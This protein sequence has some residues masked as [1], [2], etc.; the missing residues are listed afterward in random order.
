LLDFLRFF[1]F[2]RWCILF[3]EVY[4]RIS[5]R[6]IVFYYNF[7]IYLSNIRF[8]KILW[9]YFIFQRLFDI[10]L[11]IAVSLDSFSQ[12]RILIYYFISKRKYP[13]QITLFI[14]LIIFFFLFLNFFKL[15]I[16]NNSRKLFLI[17]ILFI[18]FFILK[19]IQRFFWKSWCWDLST[20][21]D[22]LWYFYLKC[23]IDFSTD[24]LINFTFRLLL[25]NL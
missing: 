21:S 18:F 2:L 3:I 8:I 16:I 4:L 23:V 1:R 11:W 7:I 20:F 10:F 24:L 13:L 6:I 12:L 15:H 14:A 19:T 25:I 9:I 5:F 17:L 22:M